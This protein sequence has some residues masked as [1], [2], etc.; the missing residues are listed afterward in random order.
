HGIEFGERAALYGLLAD[1]QAEVAPVAA[2]PLIGGKT[3]TG[4]ARQLKS[5][6]DQANAIGSVIDATPENAREAITAAL[7]GFKGWSRT[8]GEVRA[9]ILEKASGLL[10]QRAAHFI[11]LL[12]REGGKTLDDS[13]SEL[14]E[15][16][17]FCRYYAAEGRK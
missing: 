15:A 6:I 12:Q 1:L 17:D 9:E 10:E 16:V 8:T 3:G 11:A 13:L 14:R 5:P 2:A 4:A 7:E